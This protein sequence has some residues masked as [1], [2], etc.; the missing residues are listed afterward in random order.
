M[1]KDTKQ[2][3]LFLKTL[4]SGKKMYYYVARDEN[5][6]RHQ[7]STGKTDQQKTLQFCLERMAK[8]K[9]ISKTK[10]S[11]SDYARDFYDYEKSP[12]IQ[13]KLSR[14]FTYSRTCADAKSSFIRNEA[15][16]Y[17]KDVP[18][19]LISPKDI[20]GFIAHL[21]SAG[22]KNST[23]NG[24][25]KALRQVF[26]YALRMHDIG[27]DPTTEIM[28][29]RNDTEE[30]GTFTEKETQ[31]LFGQADSLEGYWNGDKSAYTM[32][33][34]ALQTGCRLG[35]IQALRVKDVQDGCILVSRSWNEKYGIGTTKTGKNRI[36][37]VSDGMKNRLLLIMWGKG[38]DDFLFGNRDGKRPVA[39]SRIYASFR[40]AL[41]KLGIDDEERIRRNLSFHCWRHTF[42]SRLANANVPELY[43]RRLTGHSS[44]RILD[45]YSHI[46]IDKLKEAMDF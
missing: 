6:R 46:Q 44:E 2:F 39:R 20:E 12:Y 25:I 24:K 17:F 15:I 33:L 10:L 43:I 14:G 8:G 19:S 40:S 3:V 29:F 37:P 7:Y 27:F 28:L 41:A 18:I 34:L 30:K 23:L 31:A 4:K 22:I 36:I 1:R 5:N 35:E 45:T 11:F 42:A 38:D 32:N 9:L 16:P 13:G 21:K 26:R